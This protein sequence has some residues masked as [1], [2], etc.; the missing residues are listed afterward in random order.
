MCKLCNN[1]NTNSMEDTNHFM[2]I[3]SA[4][5]TIREEEFAILK[6]DL[7][8]HNFSKFW[9]W[10]YFGNYEVKYFLM[11]ENLFVVDNTLGLIFDRSCKSYINRA[12][13]HRSQLRTEEKS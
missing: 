6:N 4:L 3:C 13:K 7:L 8:A 12:W 1:T 10:F 5:S 2:F 9:D 11:L